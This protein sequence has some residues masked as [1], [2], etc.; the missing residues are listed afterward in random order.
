MR[1]KEIY[2]KYKYAAS[3]RLPVYR[4]IFFTQDSNY[5]HW[6]YKFNKRL[7]DYREKQ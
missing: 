3:Y 4:L 6:L 5:R 2:E 7:K 1:N